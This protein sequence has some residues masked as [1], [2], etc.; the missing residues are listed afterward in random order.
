MTSPPEKK[1]NDNFIYLTEYYDEYLLN[2]LIQH[3]EEFSSRVS[4][5]RDVN[6][7]PFTLLKKYHKKGSFGKIEVVYKQTDGRGRF[8]AVGQTS[9]QCIS[10]KLRHTIGGDEYIDLDIVNCHPNLAEQK[11]KEMELPTPYLTKFNKNRDKI[12]KPYLDAGA[13]KDQVKIAYLSMLN[14]GRGD[15]DALP[16]STTFGRKFK[17]EMKRIHNYFVSTSPLTEFEKVRKKRIRDGKDRNHEAGFMNHKLQDYENMC[18]MAMYEFFGKPKDCV[19]VFDGMQLRK[20]KTDAF[21]GGVANFD[22]KKLEEFIFKKTGFKIKIKEKKMDEGFN[23]EIPTRS[24]SEVEKKDTSRREKIW[25][26]CVKEL[27]IHAEND[28]LDDFNISNIIEKLYDN[29]VKVSTDK[30]RGFFWNNETRVWESSSFFCLTGLLSHSRY[31]FH[32][33][34]VRAIEVSMKK[35]NEFIT[36]GLTKLKKRAGSVSFYRNIFD[37]LRFNNRICDLDFEA[38]LNNT[39]YL[40]PIKGGKVIN[41]KTGETRKREKTDMFSRECDVEYIPRGSENKT[42]HSFIDPIFGN[43][44]ELI[45]YKQ[46]KIGSYLSGELPQREIDIDMGSGANGKSAISNT[47][48]S[49]M[50]GF[51]GEAPKSIISSP[52][53]ALRVKQGSAHTADLETLRGKR[54][55][56]VNELEEGDTFNCEIFKKIASGDAIVS[57]GCGEKNFEE[58][59]TTIKLLISTNHMAKFSIT[60]SAMISRINLCPYKTRFRTHDDIE[61]EKAEGTYDDSKYLYVEANEKLSSSFSTDGEM[62]SLFFSWMVDGCIKAY[63]NTTIKKPSVIVE[64]QKQLLEQLDV[65]SAFLEDE[66]KVISVDDFLLLSK[67]DKKSSTTK[68]KDLWSAFNSWAH[69]EGLLKGWTRNKF[70]SYLKARFPTKMVHKQLHFERITS[71]NDLE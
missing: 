6:C 26:S 67:A 21:T 35:N 55:V 33:A 36:N 46:Q 34:I 16:T 30:G 4:S 47:I 31:M 57:R 17:A 56:A 1:T 60:D 19:L 70:Y 10:R 38:K 8:C 69:L 53:K 62:K 28:T 2:Y 65:P 3:E 18:L 25:N 52:E 44:E 24:I 59:K 43:D 50:G 54:F 11:C 51:A 29:E 41:L 61:R 15:Y 40:F 49:I 13:T 27:I 37:M 66:C 22:F 7:P 64:F 39:P 42:L 68:A 12:F 63:S 23:N 58:I 45:N 48:K 9:Q 14:G 71:L 5:R 20:S 32:E